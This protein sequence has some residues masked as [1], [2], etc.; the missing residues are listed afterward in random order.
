MKYKV[1]V[2][3]II[4]HEFEV[5]ASSCEEA[6]QAG[7]DYLRNLPNHNFSPCADIFLDLDD[8]RLRRTQIQ[9]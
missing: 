9:K 7:H 6:E 2:N 3:C 5:E 1:Y 8:C 4:G